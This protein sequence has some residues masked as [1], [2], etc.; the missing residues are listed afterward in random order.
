MSQQTFFSLNLTLELFQL[1]EISQAR[2]L[3]ER[4]NS[5]LYSWKTTG[6][7]N[8]LER[9]ASI[10]DVLGIVVLPDGLPEQIDLP[11][12]PPEWL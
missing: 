6:V 8:W 1:E 3:A 11:N 9:G 7:F 5:V 4:T 12:D 10:T 2:A